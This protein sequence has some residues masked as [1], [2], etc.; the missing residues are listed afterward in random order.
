MHADQGHS[1]TFLLQLH[2]WFSRGLAPEDL[3]GAECSYARGLDCLR[4]V[5]H[6]V[7]KERAGAAG[8]NSAQEARHVAWRSRSLP[9]NA[10]SCCVTETRSLFSKLETQQI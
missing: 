8:D 10:E 4:F 1:S 5:T 6:H 3:V 7:V 2:T 9:Q